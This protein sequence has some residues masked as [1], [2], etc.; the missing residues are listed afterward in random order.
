MISRKLEY[1]EV[2]AALS[3]ISSD[4]RDTWWR[5]A[6]AVKS[7]L[8][9]MGFNVWDDWS[10]TSHKY[11][12][13]AAKSVWKSVKEAGS[14]TIATLIHEARL[15]GWKPDIAF[16]PASQEQIAKIQAERK[17]AQEF[18]DAEKKR[19]NDEAAEQ[20]KTIWEAATDCTA[21][22]YLARKGVA[23]FGLRV[24]R[25]TK[26]NEETGEIWLDVPDALL[27]PIRSGQ[28]LVSLQAIFVS[29]PKPGMR[30]KDYL[31]GGKKRGCCMAIG[32]VSGDDPTIVICEGYATGATIHMA[33]GFPVV[34]AFDAGN[35][36]T[37]AGKLREKFPHAT[38]VIAGD[39]DAWTTGNPGIKHATE[40]ATSCRAWVAIPQFDDP[41]SKPTDFNDLQKLQG[42][43]AVANQIHAAINPDLPAETP[44]ETAIADPKKP[45]AVDYASTLPQCN[46]KGTPMAT[47]D[48]L[49]EII[50]RLRVTVRYNIIKKEV[51]ILIPGQGFSIDNEANAAL[52]WLMSECARFSFPTDKITDF[53]C[54]I[55][56]QNQYNPVANW[57]LSREWDGVSRIASLYST[58][59][60]ENEEN[61][62][63]VGRL[64][65]IMIKRWMVSAIAAAF[66]HSGV[67]AHGVLV[68]Q[69][70]QYLGKT[71]WFKSLVPAELG[72]IKDGLIL[73]PDDRDS[74]KKVVSNWLVELGEL[75]ATF[76]RSDISQ[77]KS[78]LTADRDILRRP[79]A[80]LESSYA[81]RTV[82]FASVNPREFLHD[83]TGNRRYWT[84]SCVELNHQHGIDTQQLWREVYD[85]LYKRGE[86][87]FLTGDELAMLN[88]HNEEFEV[89]DPICE[90]LSS[91][92]D[93]TEKQTFW[94]WVSATD[95]MT[96]M[97]FDRPTHGDSTK[98]A[99]HIRKL[100]GGK[101]KRSGAQRLLLMPNLKR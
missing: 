98:A 84:I 1:N 50:R 8:G 11:N 76:R 20:A 70:A 35:L 97:G 63:A 58:I 75:D 85:T 24:G 81:R 94:R 27:V 48:N 37:V 44:Q 74:V 53:L 33:T 16:E 73:R 3:Y 36:R 91:M 52:A 9:D 71:A 96:E 25:W 31:A 6:M 64:K 30:D 60:A 82:F 46:S 15:S 72:V 29:P 18:A 86:S 26:V 41:S 93:W 68:L 42:L 92:Y 47:I 21:H 77:L 83:N 17:A 13:G 4:D 5:M 40:A 23:S 12:R 100:N 80:R 101:G 89:V 62:E 65:E 34:V 22:P 87:W 99:H 49:R 95:V 43:E 88:N 66:N 45:F 39:N 14:V 90:R 55:G 59:K 56:D 2:S 51:E 78:F 67:S 79:Y 32:A 38:L 69:G 19:R 10:A 28:K 7:E 54:F 61:D 57:I